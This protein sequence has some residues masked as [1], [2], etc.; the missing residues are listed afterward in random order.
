MEIGGFIYRNQIKMKSQEL[1]KIVE[2]W[3]KG[4]EVP[5]QKFYKLLYRKTFHSIKKLVKSSSEAEEIFMEGLHTFLEHFF[6]GNKPLPNNS[7]SYFY[8][9]CYNIWYDERIKKKHPHAFDD[10]LDM[11]VQP[12]DTSL[13]KD[14]DKGYKQ[15]AWA[16]AIERLKGLCKKI[17][18]LH[19]EEGQKLKTIWQDLEFK[20]YQ[21][22]VQANYR[23][24]KRLTQMVLEEY[25][26]LLKN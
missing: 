18:Q 4:N 1:Q 14:D 7:F 5:F 20:N 26:A 8:R 6:I 15:I 22:L 13:D 16:K 25:D 9:I 24:K 17:F 19:I 11:P 3:E 23:C 10:K 2:E 12:T 21:S